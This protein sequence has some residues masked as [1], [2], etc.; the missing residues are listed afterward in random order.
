MADLRPMTIRNVLSIALLGLVAACGGNGNEVNGS[1][2]GQSIDVADGFL[3]PPRTSADGSAVSLVVLESES[4]A[5]SF[6]QSRALNNTRLVTIALG[7]TTA[8]GIFVPADVAGTYQIGAPAFLAAGTK[9]A[10]VTFGVVGSC[11]LGTT[12]QATS[13]AVH[14]NNVG[15]N[16]DGSIA[17][18]EGTFEAVFANSEKLSGTFRVSY[19]AG[20]RLI[21]GV[22]R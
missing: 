2:Q 21:F 19:C 20:A 22:C 4:D 9:L 5:C 7:V 15:K 17:G 11:G 6:A 12:G 14:L 3:M 1:Y 8:N 10:G 18:M 16:A 13:G